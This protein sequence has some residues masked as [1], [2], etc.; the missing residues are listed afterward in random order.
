MQISLLY[1]HGAQASGAT[2]QRS[3][4][5]TAAMMTDSLGVPTSQKA[6]SCCRPTTTTTQPVRAYN[7][8]N[9][10]SASE[11]EFL[12]MNKGMVG[13]APELCIR[14]YCMALPNVTFQVVSK[15]GNVNTNDAY[16]SHCSGLCAEVGLLIG[17][18]N[19]NGVA[20]DHE[21]TLALTLEEARDALSPGNAIILACAASGSL[22]M[23]FGPLLLTVAEAL[24]FTGIG[25]NCFI[26]AML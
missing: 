12:G 18:F 26:Q 14:I 23:L 2:G 22:V 5:L 6:T 8:N 1:A 20:D 24:A 4:M 13:D 25:S 3:G 9:K 10:S 16:C 19:R 7:S 15:I 17:D 21:T 11:P